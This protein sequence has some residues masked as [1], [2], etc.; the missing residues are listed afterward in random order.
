MRSC[1]GNLTEF[2]E[3]T[4]S[5]LSD[6]DYLRVRNSL[7]QL[8]SASEQYLQYK[9]KDPKPSRLAKGRMAAAAGVKKSIGNLLEELS[10]SYREAD[11]DEMESFHAQMK[12]EAQRLNQLDKAGKAE[13][14]IDLNRLAKEKPKVF[15]KEQSEAALATLKN[16]LTDQSKPIL[17]QLP[18]AD[19]LAA[20]VLMHTMVNEIQP[21]M[22]DAVLSAMYAQRLTVEN[23][24]C[25]TPALRN[26]LTKSPEQFIAV[27]ENHDNRLKLASL[28]MQ[29]LNTVDR[30]RNVLPT[31]EKA[32]A[33][34]EAEANAPKPQEPVMK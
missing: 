19:R 22:D 1:L 21:S 27:L 34:I 33:Q 25:R 6:K 29:Q 7:E 13:Q 11:A 9:E 26:L 10:A 14:Q 3:A 12:A 28:S 24:L 23:T 15:A 31:A 30:N 8:R 20:Q 32:A 4:G 2:L 17:Q 18:D 5:P 16:R